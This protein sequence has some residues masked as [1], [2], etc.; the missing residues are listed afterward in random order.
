MLDLGRQLIRARMVY[1]VDAPPLENGCLSIVDGRIEAIGPANR[2][3]GTPTDLGDVALLPGFVNVHTHL[4]FSHLTEPLGEPEQG[5][6]DWIRAAISERR[7]RSFRPAAAIGAGCRE[8]LRAGVTTVGEIATSN[9]SAY[10]RDSTIPQLTIFR[11]VIGFSRARA[12]SAFAATC[13]ELTALDSMSVESPD[14]DAGISPHAPYTVSPLLLERLVEYSNQHRIPIAMHLAES[15]DELELLR[16]GTGPFRELLEE[17]SMWDRE[18]LRAGGAPLDYLK[19]L[20]RSPRALVVHGN[21]LNSTE[22]DFLAA[23]RDRLSLVHCPRTHAYFGHAPFDVGEVIANGVRVVLATDSRASNP[24][25]SLLSELRWV[26][27]RHTSLSPL[28]VLRLGTLEAAE[29]LGRGQSIGSLSVA[30]IANLL[31]VPLP[32]GVNG[33]GVE[34]LSA[35]LAGD[36]AP[37]HVWLRGAPVEIG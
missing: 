4:E 36:E 28:L 11:E 22:L 15:H 27:A 9:T 23:H 35:V 19:Q 33:S 29:A 3:D 26:S 21:Y 5:F 7:R 6:V 18:V 17:R 12:D 32:A 10:Q 31:A 20:A 13:E 1:P 16:N 14:V 37:S 8:S 2:A 24:D 25:L 34:L 30:K